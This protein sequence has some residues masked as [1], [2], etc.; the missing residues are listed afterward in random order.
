[1]PATPGMNHTAVPGGKLEYELRG[2]GE[3]VLF[4]HGA[5]IADS[6]LPLMGEPSLASYRLIRY[7]RRGHAGSSPPEGPFSIEQEA[8][9]A[10]ALLQHLNV[11]RTHV[12]GHSSGGVIALQLALD[13]PKVVHSLVLI[14][15]AL[16]T[17]NPAFSDW[18]APIIERYRSGDASGAVDAF[19]APM[20]RSPWRTEV[21]R[22]VPE[23]PEQAD[24]D[25]KAFF[26]V[27]IVAV[28]GWTWDD[29]KAAQISQ[30]TLYVNQSG[31]NW[32]E[33][34]H[35]IHAWFPKAEHYLVDNVT[36][37]LPMQDFLSRHHI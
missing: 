35:R 20:A 34:K 12:V 5:H 21:A 9:D 27:E 36:H 13:A 4:I 18:I 3:P 7:H 17:A 25:A 11:E 37:L 30:P 29:S 14:E 22:T 32:E 26:E 24:R 6:F 33:K 10:L 16:M 2:D 31:P 1:M 19:M 23:G 28:L 15:P 8:A